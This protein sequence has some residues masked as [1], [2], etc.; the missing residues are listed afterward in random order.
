MDYQ[1]PPIA[2]TVHIRYLSDFRQASDKIFIVSNSASTK[3]PTSATVTRDPAQYPALGGIVLKKM[4]SGWQAAKPDFSYHGSAKMFVPEKDATCAIIFVYDVLRAEYRKVM[5]RL[6]ESPAKPVE[7]K[8][9][10][11][12]IGLIPDYTN[13]KGFRLTEAYTKSIDGKRVLVIAGKDIDIER[14]FY[15]VY[16]SDTDVGFETYTK[17]WFVGPLEAPVQYKKEAIDAINSLKFL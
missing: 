8:D 5:Q 11:Q 9:L 1:E 16:S 17:I 7:D 4:P 6:L 3:K 14:D 2:K 12:L 15:F 13:D 10:Q